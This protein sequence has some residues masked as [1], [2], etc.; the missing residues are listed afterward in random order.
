MQF[1]KLS[2]FQNQWCFNI[3]IS[4]GWL[5]AY[6]IRNFD[7]QGNGKLTKENFESSWKN[8]AVNE[9]YGDPVWKLM[10]KKLDENHNGIVT[11]QALLD[12]EMADDGKSD[13]IFLQISENKR[14][15]TVHGKTNEHVFVYKVKNICSKMMP[16]RVFELN[17]AI[18]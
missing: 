12:D 14:Y 15:T 8:N 9:Q 6:F 3:Y 16:S 13:L 17:D 18:S 5:R 10:E 7:D 2:V 1:A 4:D 11:L